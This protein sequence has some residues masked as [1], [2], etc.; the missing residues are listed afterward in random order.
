MER[1]RKHT[2]IFYSTHIL[3]DVQRVSDTV[4]ILNQ[5]ALVA[6]G[7]IEELL[8]GGQAAVFTLTVKG[9]SASVEARLRSQP[10]VTGIEAISKNGSVSW[11]IRVSDP[12]LAEAHL[13]PL[14][15]AG[16]GVT[17][18]EFGRKAQNLEDVF[19]SIVKESNHEH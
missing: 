14:A 17:V 7:P 15:L 11:R 6:Q 2:T 1:L 18:C 4:I 10:W 16:G 9:D 13:V 3:D 8:A 19:L 5:G 12:D